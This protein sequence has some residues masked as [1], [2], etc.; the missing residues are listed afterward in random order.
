LNLIVLSYFTKQKCF[1]QQMCLRS[2]QIW[3]I[4]KCMKIICFRSSSIY[5]IPDISHQ[6]FLFPY[7]ENIFCKLKSKMLLFSKLRYKSHKFLS[8][9]KIFCEK[10]SFTLFKSGL[11][12]TSY[13]FYFIFSIKRLKKVFFWPETFFSIFFSF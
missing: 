8:R 1:N 3:F 5:F 9:K 7:D 12:N 10:K 6:L 11:L 2:F 4:F 13:F